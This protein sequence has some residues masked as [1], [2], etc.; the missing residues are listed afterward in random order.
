VITFRSNRHFSNGRKPLISLGGFR[1]YTV[2]NPVPDGFVVMDLHFQLPARTSP[3]LTIVHSKQTTTMV[4]ST[5]K[6]KMLTEEFRA[7]IQGACARAS[8]SVC[9]QCSRSMRNVSRTKVMTIGNKKP[10]TPN[11]CVV[12][13]M[14][15]YLPEPPFFSTAKTFRGISGWYSTQEGKNECLAQRI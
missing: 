7:K 8:A 11:I 9:A 15:V 14:F 5:I 13:F 3:G 4:I 1:R 6:R 2:G 12:L 10:S